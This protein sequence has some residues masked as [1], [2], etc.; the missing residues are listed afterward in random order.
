MPYLVTWDHSFVFKLVFDDAEYFSSQFSEEVLPNDIVAIPKYNAYMRLMID[1]M[2]SRPFSLATLPPPD[3]DHE[4]GRREKIVRLSRERYCTPRDVVEDKIFRWAGSGKKELN[5]G[6]GKK[7]PKG[8]GAPKPNDR[9]EELPKAEP[10]TEKPKEAHT[11]PKSEAPKAP[12][13]HENKE[14]KGKPR[15]NP[16]GGKWRGRPPRPK[17]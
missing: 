6:E 11:K 8:K 5:E 7:L 12:A 16:K 9:K 15:F 17:S 13:Q 14:S 2:P 1:G 4:E 10:K 3:M